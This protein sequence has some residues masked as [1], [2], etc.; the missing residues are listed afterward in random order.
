VFLPGQ[1]SGANPASPDLEKFEATPANFASQ[2]MRE[3]IEGTLQ[4]I[5]P[6]SC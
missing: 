4:L 2:E 3:K 6:L 5:F 1:T